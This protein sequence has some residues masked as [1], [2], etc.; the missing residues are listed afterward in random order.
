MGNN[1]GCQQ[2]C[3]VAD[4]TADGYVCACY[5]G[6]AFINGT[7]MDIDECATNNGGCSHNCFNFD[8]GY[9]CSCPEGLALAPDAHTCG[10]ACIECFGAETNEECN[11]QGYRVCP[12]DS[13]A[14]ENEVRVHGGKK[15]IFKQQTKEGLPQQ[16]H[17]KS[18]RCLA[19]KSMQRRYRQRCL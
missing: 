13:D 18:K 9:E 7:C 3:L 11:A 16:L 2:D 10:R 1:G 14:C 8:G 4:G 6:Y 19:S 12:P 15:Y 5:A 17:P